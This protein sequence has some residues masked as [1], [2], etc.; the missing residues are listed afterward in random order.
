MSTQ[1]QKQ[2]G[3]DSTDLPF[4]ILDGEPLAQCAIRKEALNVSIEQR[5]R[6]KFGTQK[7]ATEPVWYTIRSNRIAG[8]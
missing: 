6:I 4:L 5:E 8:S 1:T 7:Q 2:E 3:A